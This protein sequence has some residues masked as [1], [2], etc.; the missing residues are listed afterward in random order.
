[1]YFFE[2]YKDSRGHWRWRF[3]APNG[4]IVADSAEGYVSKQGALDGIALVQRYAPGAAV[5]EVS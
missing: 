3:K 2:L 1:M 5:R 4:R